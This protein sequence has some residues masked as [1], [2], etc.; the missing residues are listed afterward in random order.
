[1]GCW[2]YS[3]FSL[4]FSLCSVV[5]THVFMHALARHIICLSGEWAKTFFLNEAEDIH[6]E[7][8]NW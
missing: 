1:M 5:V 2:P 3:D 4:H 7:S 6:R 8:K